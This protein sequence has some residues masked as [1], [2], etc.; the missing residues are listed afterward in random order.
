MGFENSEIASITLG[1]DIECG[2]ADAFPDDID[3]DIV[4]NLRE[5]IESIA[6]ERAR[7]MAQRGLKIDCDDDLVCVTFDVIERTI[8]VQADV[9]V[10]EKCTL[11]FD[12]AA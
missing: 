9:W 7:K 3:E 2:L 12:V 11:S 8:T 10:T 1:K 4:E 6:R 5:A